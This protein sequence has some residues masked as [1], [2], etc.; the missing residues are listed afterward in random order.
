MNII[1]QAGGQGRRL[2]KYTTNI[3]KCLISV[4]ENILLY[5]TINVL[6]KSFPGSNFYVVCDYKSEV[7]SN[8]FESYPH[9]LSPQLIT[10][11][12]IGTCSG[13]NDA[14]ST[15]NNEPL[16]IVWCDLYFDESSFDNFDITNG[17]NIIGLS[18]EFTCRWSLNEEDKLLEKSSST[19]GVAGVFFFKEP[20]KVLENLPPSGEFVRWLSLKNDFKFSGQYIKNTLELGD[21]KQYEALKTTKQSRCRFFNNVIFEDNHVIKECIDSDFE[22][23]IDNEINW[24][25]YVSDQGFKYSPGIFSDSP[26]TMER[27]I[28]DHPDDLESDEKILSSCLQSL[29]TLHKLEKRPADSNDTSSVYIQ[30]TFERVKKVS[31][32]LPIKEKNIIINDITYENPFHESCIANEFDLIKE[33]L[34]STQD[35]FVPIHGDPTFSNIIYSSRNNKA[36]FIDPRGVFGNSQIFGDRYYDIAK[37]LYS[38]EGSYDHFNKKDFELIS[39]SGKEFYLTLP[40]SKYKQHSHIIYEQVERPERLVLIHSLIW[41]SLCGYVK[42][43][44]NSIVGAFLKGIMVYN[45]Y[46]SLLEST[47]RSIKLSNL[48]KTWIFD[49]DGTLVL[50]NGHI[51]NEN[52]DFLVGVESFLAENIEKDDVILLTTSRTKEESSLIF[53]KVKHICNCDVRVISSLPFGERLLFNDDKPSGL[54]TAHAINLQR[55]SGL[56][57]VIIRVDQS[58]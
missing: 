26:L 46:K 12:G 52:E 44:I 48:P 24:Y 33:Y 47:E 38:A 54:K 49:I 55:D 32:L 9:H 4:N 6:D 19:S 39:Y 50:H 8:Y 15:L 53:E 18:S 37:L 13:I 30:K 2:Q 14:L 56:E 22:K 31:S 40:Q 5:H 17:E 57:N 20:I 16:L 23:L 41:F 45:K 36:Y 51:S 7:V 3:P 21:I 29:S 28:G 43:H 1:I 42:D 34:L 58:I 10:P 27:I 25:N 35:D 11:K